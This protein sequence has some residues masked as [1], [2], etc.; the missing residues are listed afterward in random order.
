MAQA[1]ALNVSKLD[2]YSVLKASDV[3]LSKL[4]GYAVLKGVELHVSKFNVYAVLTPA[5]TTY[6][7]NGSILLLGI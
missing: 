6:R 7:S 3:R 4:N 5:P 1:D 2:A